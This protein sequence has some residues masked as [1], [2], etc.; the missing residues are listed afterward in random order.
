M[1]ILCLTLSGS[2]LLFLAGNKQKNPRTPHPQ[3]RTQLFKERANSCLQQAPTAQHPRQSVV[4][5]IPAWAVAKA[6][7]LKLFCKI[8]VIPWGPKGE[9]KPKERCSGAEV[10]GIFWKVHRVLLSL[11][12]VSPL[13]NQ[14]RLSPWHRCPSVSSGESA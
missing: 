14:R 4:A 12:A 2:F 9:M 5:H 13:F 1:S 7:D 11:E 3:K 8:K 6:S 10:K